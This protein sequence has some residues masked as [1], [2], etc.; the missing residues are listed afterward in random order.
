MSNHL[1][2]VTKIDKKVNRPENRKKFRGNVLV[3]ISTQKY[4]AKILT[5]SDERLGSEKNVFI[6]LKT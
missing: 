2:R 5:F 4:F 1:I 6:F 3:E